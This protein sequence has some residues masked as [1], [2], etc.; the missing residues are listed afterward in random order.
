MAFS[1]K[2]VNN[3]IVLS[4]TYVKITV[5]KN[6]GTVEKVFCKKKNCDISGEK[7]TLFYVT[8][9]NYKPYKTNSLTLNNSTVTVDTELGKFD[10]EIK[11]FDSYFTFELTTELPQ[12]AYAFIMAHIKYGYDPED[13]VNCT[14]AGVS[15]TYWTHPFCWVDEINRKENYARVIRHLKDKGAKYGLVIAPT[16]EHREILKKMCVTI[17]RNVG[18]FSSI[19]GA[20]A[21]D[22]RINYT[23]YIIQYHTDPEYFEKNL[24]LYRTLGVDQIDYH[25]NNH[26]TLGSFRQGDFHFFHYSSAENFKKKVTDVLEENGMSAG[27]H[28]YGAYIDQN[29]QALLS[30]PENLRQLKIEKTFTL[31]SDI[32]KDSEYL[33]LEGDTDSV[34]TDDSFYTLNSPFI[35]IDDEL[36]KFEKVDNKFKI[37]KRG[38]SGTKITDHKKGADVLYP[39]HLYWCFVPRFDSE[40][41][42]EVARRT[43]KAYN[44]GGFNMIYLDAFEV[45]HK[46]AHKDEVSFYVGKF[47]NEMLKN[48]KTDPILESSAGGAVIWQTVC[49]GGAMDSPS[50]AYKRF[51]KRHAGFNANAKK[52]HNTATLGW[53]DY[54]PEGL[55][56]PGN[57]LVKYH[58]TDD[59]DHMGSIAVIHDYS[60][61][62]NGPSFEKYNRCAGARKNIARYKKYDDLRKAQ[63]FSEEYREKMDKSEY[64]LCLVEKRGARY[65]FVEKSYSKKKL[66]NLYDAERNT[67]EF[68][69]PFS[70][71]TPFVRIEALLST[72]KENPTLLLSLDE[73]TDLEKQTLKVEY[74]ELLDIDDKRAKT[75]RILGNG[76]KGSAIAIKLRSVNAL[77]LIEYVIDT[78]F[79]GWRDFILVETDN[80]EREDLPFDNNEHIWSVY[81]SQFQNDKVKSLEIESAGDISGVKMSSIEAT[82]HLYDSLKNPTVKIGESEVMFECELFSSDYI[83]FDGTTAKVIDRYGN[84]KK[85]FF[86]STLQAPKGKFKAEL[87]AKS[88]NRLVPRAILTLGFTGKEIK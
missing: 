83:E 70:T 60:T 51:N 63:Y 18:I 16:N 22:H 30:V 74:P 42:L 84:E 19:G 39:H 12:K 35:I 69:N 65:S 88:L 29:A 32:K 67:A 52:A 68:E 41:F 54:Y 13:S 31:T 9:E 58:H 4:N 8:D 87:T 47:V 55:N 34:K 7:T 21:R 46:Y 49:R 82:E 10:V 17:D 15:M 27:L 86:T 26:E 20:F 53:Y 6:E 77:T 48:C 43:A 44:E 45:I 80:G 72:K 1:I 66:Y 64:D 56:S 57:E 50:R 14:T 40:L 25:H 24:P 85:I 28:T 71:Q 73:T 37:V 76:K 36:I 78:D 75:V 5:S 3:S 79:T 61:A 11:A 33:E 81:G 62:F 2:E 38:Y 23:N 59:I